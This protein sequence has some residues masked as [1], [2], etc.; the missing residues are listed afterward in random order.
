MG[1]DANSRP[2]G[3]I[4]ERKDKNAAK[5]DAVNNKLGE[6]KPIEGGAKI[7]KQ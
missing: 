3:G 2:Y 4:D 7:N 1:A 5:L 6:G